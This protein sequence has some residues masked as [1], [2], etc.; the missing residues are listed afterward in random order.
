MTPHN[1]WALEAARKNHTASCDYGKM[2]DEPWPEVCV[3]CEM[4]LAEEAD[5]I[6]S[7]LFAAV[8]G[9][10]EELAKRLESR[11]MPHVCSGA[12]PACDAALLLRAQAVENAA[13]KAR[14]AELEHEDMLDDLGYGMRP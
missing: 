5:R 3:A 14:I 8:P 9:E 2:S 6:R 10:V 1:D 4:P 11:E 12:C 7:C 13:L